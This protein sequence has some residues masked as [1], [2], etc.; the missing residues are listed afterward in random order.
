MIVSRVVDSED[1]EFNMYSSRNQDLGLP[2]LFGTKR[3][4]RNSDGL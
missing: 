4:V 1:L 2:A 3:V